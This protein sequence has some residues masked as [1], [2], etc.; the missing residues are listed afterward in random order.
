MG[1]KTCEEV[2]WVKKVR[3]ETQEMATAGA[4]KKPR[5]Q[6]KRGSVF[7][8]KKRLVKKLMFDK[9][10]KSIASLFASRRCSSK[11][12]GDVKSDKG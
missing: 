10:V 7:P 4:D 9:I 12:T 6:S 3:D 11:A 1:V 8:E 2:T 5:F